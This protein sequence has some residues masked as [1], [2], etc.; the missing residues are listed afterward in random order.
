MLP[1]GIELAVGESVRLAE[2]VLT[3]LEIH[4][5]EITLRIDSLGDEADGEFCATG[6]LTMQRP[7]R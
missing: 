5:D 1:S 3:I 6:R 4:G 2:H 7:P